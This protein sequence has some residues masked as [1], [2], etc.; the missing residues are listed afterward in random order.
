MV[1]DAADVPFTWPVIL[2]A[3]TA[4]T[5]ITMSSAQVTKQMAVHVSG[6]SDVLH[7]T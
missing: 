5:N 2:D 1:C 6:R 7:P 4:G 3:M